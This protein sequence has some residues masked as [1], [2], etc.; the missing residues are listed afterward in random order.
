MRNILHLPVDLY[1]LIASDEQLSRHDLAAMRLARKAFTAPAASVLFRRVVL[2]RLKQDRDTLEHIA[3]SD[4][5]ACYVRELVWQELDLDAWVGPGQD[6]L[7]GPD[8]TSRDHPRFR[9]E[10]DDYLQVKQLMADAAGDQNLFWFPRMSSVADLQYEASPVSWF[11]ATVRKFPR[12]T[13]LVSCPMPRDRTFM[14]KEYPLQPDLYYRQPVAYETRTSNIGFFSFMLEAMRQIP[15]KIQSLTW[16]DEYFH[17][18]LGNEIRPWDLAAFKSLKI[19]ELCPSQLSLRDSNSIVQCLRAATHLESLTLHFD[20]SAPPVPS[21]L[22]TT[23][24]KWCNWPNLTYLEF[25]H[26]VFPPNDMVQFLGRCIGLRHLVLR[27]CNISIDHI[28]ELRKAALRQLTS[29][30]VT[31]GSH[32]LLESS[33]LDFVNQTSSSLVGLDGENMHLL[34]RDCTIHTEQST[35]YEDLTCPDDGEHTTKF[36]EE[37]EYKYWS[38]GRF[39]K[40]R[41]VHYW[42]VDKASEAQSDTTIWRF[43]RP[44]GEVWHSVED[45]MEY[46]SDWDSDA[47]DEATPVPGGEAFPEFCKT[48]PTNSG[49]MPTPKAYLLGLMIKAQT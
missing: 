14:Y 29:I 47:G 15:P 20:R 19:I 5:L 44:N 28:L 18:D 35:R 8:G 10:P 4:H 49:A 3:A 32:Q 38:W 7:F 42:P 2:S 13:A 1:M 39:G 36:G 16:H 6:E 41:E 31:G 25:T 33:L 27:E 40:E 26:A 37:H 46:L 34:P 23:V 48:S 30:I 21:V 9:L 45:P 22:V 17:K 12:L 24:L 11:I 43:K